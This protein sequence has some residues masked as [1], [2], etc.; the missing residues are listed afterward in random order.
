MTS[1]TPGGRFIHLSYRELM[2]NE[3]MDIL[4]SYLTCVLHTARISYVEIVL[5]GERMKDGKFEAH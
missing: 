4:G 1:Q 3:A 5:Y 2:G